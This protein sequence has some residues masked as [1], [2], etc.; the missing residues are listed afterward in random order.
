MLRAQI[1]EGDSIVECGEERGEAER[2][3]E[4]LGMG[5]LQDCRVADISR[6]AELQIF[7]G[8]QKCRNF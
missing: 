2:P 8:L 3:N 5:Y 7:A 1:D 4:N 6:A